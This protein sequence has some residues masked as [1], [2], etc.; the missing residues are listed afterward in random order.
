VRPLLLRMGAVCLLRLASHLAHLWWV[1]RPNAPVAWPA[2]WLEA[3]VL[4][5]LG[6]A[7]C[8]AWRAGLRRRV[9]PADRAAPLPHP[10]PRPARAGAR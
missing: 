4:A 3:A 9:S 6:L 7:W 10:S 5:G 8:A 1:V 2:P